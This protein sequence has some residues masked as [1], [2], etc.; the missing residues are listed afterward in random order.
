MGKIEKEGFLEVFKFFRKADGGFI[1]EFLAS[2]DVKRIPSGALIYTEGDK[3]PG[4]AFLLH[5]EIRVYKTSESGREIT[6][7]E[8][9]P[10]ET[11]VLNVSCIL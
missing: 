6:L 3:C 5:G 1:E 8:I 7:Y 9:F 4:I 10:G 11:C 2:A